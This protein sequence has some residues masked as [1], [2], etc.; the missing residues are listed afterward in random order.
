MHLGP[1][2]FAGESLLDS[3][4]N[5]ETIQL[6]NYTHAKMDCLLDGIRESLNDTGIQPGT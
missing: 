2:E 3:I 4:R 6:G 5:L 1:M